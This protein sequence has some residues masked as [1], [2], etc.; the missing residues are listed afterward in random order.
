MA[1]LPS[2]PK[3]RQKLL[4]GALPLL[5]LGA[6]WFFLHGSKVEEIERLESRLESLE[7]K[8]NTARARAMAGG[9][10]ELEQKLALYEEHVAWLEELVPRSE[11]VPELLYAISLRAQESRVDLAVFNPGEDSPGPYY[12][13][14]TF[15]IGVLGGYHDIGRFL[16]AIGSLSRIVTPYDLVLAPRRTSSPDEPFQVQATF[17]IKT[18]VI[19]DEED[20]FGV[21]ERIHAST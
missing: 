3:A 12:T 6:Y 9:V 18:Y 15:E 10:L 2:D 21:E 1:P 5:L 20:G 17:R 7:S 13:L 14:K 11:E 19:P 16:T 4:L 8:N